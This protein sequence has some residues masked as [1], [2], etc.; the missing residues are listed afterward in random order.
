MRELPR[1]TR[2]LRAFTDLG[3]LK[4]CARQLPDEIFNKRLEQTEILKKYV[5]KNASFFNEI[6]KNIVKN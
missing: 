6:I 4:K 5:L 1:V 3:R 2:S